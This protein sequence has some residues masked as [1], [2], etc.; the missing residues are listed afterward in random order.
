[1]KVYHGSYTEIDIIDLPKGKIDIAIYDIGDHIV[2][3]LMIEII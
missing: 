1:M 2:R 3:A